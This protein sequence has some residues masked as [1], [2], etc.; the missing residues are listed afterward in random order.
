MAGLPQVSSL[1]LTAFMIV[2]LIVAKVMISRR[3]E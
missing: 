1:Y 3:Y 2:V